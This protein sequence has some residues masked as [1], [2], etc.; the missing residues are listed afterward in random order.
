MTMFVDWVKENPTRLSVSKDVPTEDA[1]MSRLTQ[2]E[3]KNRHNPVSAVCKS[4]AIHD[5]R[6]W[7]EEQ[8]E[9]DGRQSHFRFSD[10]TISLG[11]PERHVIWKP[12]AS[13][14][15]PRSADQDSH[16]GEPGL[17]CD[18]TVL[19]GKSCGEMCAQGN[20]T[21]DYS[22]HNEGGPKDWWEEKQWDWSPEKF[23]EGFRG[24][25]AIEE[26]QSLT[27]G[28][29]LGR[30]G[31]WDN[32]E[33]DKFILGIVGRFGSFRLGWRLEPSITCFR[34]CQHNKDCKAP[35]KTGSQIIDDSPA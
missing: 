32:L 25:D 15:T 4:E 13:Y 31:A 11:Q 34:D 18:K 24:V 16:E 22:R 21:A 20:E 6:G 28:L 10:S 17:P 29:D 1:K 26:S 27:V 5:H 8:R 12:P 14:D 35:N 30:R 19:F 23:E 9:R 7:E 33:I 2:A 3:T